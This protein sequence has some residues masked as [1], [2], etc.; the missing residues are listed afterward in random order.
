[1]AVCLMPLLAAVSWRVFRLMTGVGVPVRGRQGGGAGPLQ[2]L[3]VKGEETEQCVV[4]GA[5]AAA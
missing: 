4:G 3:F 1:M 5:A 2:A